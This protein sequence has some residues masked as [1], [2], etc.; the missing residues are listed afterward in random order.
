MKLICLTPD[1][2]RKCELQNHKLE[3][4]TQKPKLFVMREKMFGH[5]IE[6]DTDYK[7]II[8]LQNKS[9]HIVE[10]SQIYKKYE[11]MHQNN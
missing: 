9:C 5:N 1:L 6:K 3:Y 10:K 2:M 4:Y 11:E 7:Q 8:Y